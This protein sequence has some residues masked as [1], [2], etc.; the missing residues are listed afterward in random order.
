M[1]TELLDDYTKAQFP[2]VLKWGNGTANVRIVG[3]CGDQVIGYSFSHYVD[4]SG[5]TIEYLSQALVWNGQGIFAEGQ[6][7]NMNLPPPASRT[8]ER[9]AILEDEMSVRQGR[10]DAN[11]DAPVEWRT[12]DEHRIIA[13]KREIASMRGD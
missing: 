11:P 10:L 9:I 8:A 5:D 6:Y 3:A 12:I 1:Q 7:P 13:I 2:L 4:D